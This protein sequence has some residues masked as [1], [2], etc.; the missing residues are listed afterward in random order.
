MQGDFCS[1]QLWSFAHGRQSMNV[2][3]GRSEEGGLDGPKKHTCLLMVLQVLLWE[4]STLH[5]GTYPGLCRGGGGWGDFW[6]QVVSPR[7]PV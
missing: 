7:M 3:F 5:S 4:V 1:L 2:R 6:N